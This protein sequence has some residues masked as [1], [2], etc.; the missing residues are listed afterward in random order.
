[1][2]I[3]PWLGLTC[4]SGHEGSSM[5][6]SALAASAPLRKVGPRLMV[7]E[8]NQIM[9]RPKATHCGVSRTTSPGSSSPSSSSVGITGVAFSTVVRRFTWRVELETDV[10][11]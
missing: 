8:E 9:K 6:R 3:A 1:M 5:W 10:H 11:I 2:E 4:T 7:M